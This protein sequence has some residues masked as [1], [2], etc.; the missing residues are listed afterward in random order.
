MEWEWSWGEGRD[1]VWRWADDA[2]IASWPAWLSGIA[3]AVAIALAVRARRAQ[4][5][6][7]PRWAL[8]LLALPVAAW[9][10][11][12]VAL[13]SGGAALDWLGIAPLAALE[14]AG[15]A[16]AVLAWLA[17]RGRASIAALGVVAVLALPGA[18]QPAWLATIDLPSVEVEYSPHQH[19]GRVQHLRATLRR[20]RGCV[21]EHAEVELHGDEAR[22]YEVPFAIVC[23]GILRRHSVFVEVAAAEGGDFPLEPG[24]RS[25]YELTP[26]DG[27]AVERIAIEVTEAAWED[28]PLAGR[29]VRFGAATW[30]AYDLAGRT[31][32]R[33]EVQGSRPTITPLFAA[34][35]DRPVHPHELEPWSGEG[36]FLFLPL[37]W[38]CARM[39][40][41][42]PDDCA[43]SVDRTDPVTAMIGLALTGGLA[44]PALQRSADAHAHLVEPSD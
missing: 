13:A 20:P 35:P 6:A 8:A 33:D 19:V 16:A 39:A 23:P 25:V 36:P 32:L 37:G 41:A 31:Y 1:G 3:V 43:A 24:R 34:V 38:I 2:V 27:G 15:A 11:G 28:G 42:G 26:R 14:G 5:P 30:Q 12:V 21:L 18:L 44:L 10:G 9:L 22:V 7:S 40:S 4:G 29:E 17:A